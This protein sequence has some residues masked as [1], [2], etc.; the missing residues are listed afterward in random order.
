KMETREDK[1]LWQNLVEE[2]VL[3]SSMVQESSG[4]ENPQRSCTRRGSKPSPD[5]SKEERPTLCQ[6]GRQRSNWSLELVVYQQFPNG[7]KS[8]KEQP[9][10]CGECGRSFIQSSSVICHQVIYSVEWPFEC[11]E[12]GK[13]FSTS[14]DLIHH[15]QIHIK[16]R[17][18]KCPESAKR[19]QTR[20]ILLHQQIHTEERPFCCP[21]CRKGFYLN[22]S[23]ITHEHI[24]TGSR[25]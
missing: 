15:Q 4:E 8:Y 21:S 12:F 3:S 20:S 23:L 6:E 11:Q 16:E 1:S 7:E 5:C 14:S 18:Y 2:A 22:S 13:S 10:E 25:P 9:Y 17:P 19:F 24:H